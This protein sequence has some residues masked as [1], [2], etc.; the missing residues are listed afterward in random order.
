MEKDRRHL[1]TDE[2]EIKVPILFLVVGCTLYL[3]KIV[4]IFVVITPTIDR[5]SQYDD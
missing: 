1:P 4:R 3:Y 2:Y 5:Y